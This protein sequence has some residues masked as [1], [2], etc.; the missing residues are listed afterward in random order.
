MAQSEEADIHKTI[1]EQYGV[2]TRS[3]EFRTVSDQKM[4][5]AVD[6]TR[7]RSYPFLR[8]GVTVGGAIYNVKTGAIEP[9]D[10]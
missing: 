9:L 6:V 10:C 8:E 3:L 5:L 4:A 1:A 7:I 2:D